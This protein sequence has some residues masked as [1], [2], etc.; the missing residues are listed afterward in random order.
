MIYTLTKKLLI[1]VSLKYIIISI[2]LKNENIQTMKSYSLNIF[3][4]ISFLLLIK[5]I[6]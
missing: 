3:L 6:L 1:N 2:L 5:I 4:I